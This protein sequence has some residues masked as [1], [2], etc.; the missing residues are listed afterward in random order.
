MWKYIG[1]VLIL[2]FLIGEAKTQDLEKDLL[3]A[4]RNAFQ[5]STGS[6]RFNGLG[7]AMSAI[8]ADLSMI[9]HNPAGIAAFWKSEVAGTLGISVM[10]NNSVLKDGGKGKVSSSDFQFNV[11][12]GGIVFTSYTP[13][14]NWMSK[15]FGITYNRQS[16]FGNEI[17][18][19]GNSLGSITE[20]WA[21][22]AD[23]FHP[24]DLK[25][26]ANLEAWPAWLAGAIYEVGDGDSYLY[27]YDYFSYEDKELFRSQL[28]NNNGSIDELGISFGGN[29]RNTFLIGG[30]VGIDFMNFESVKT[31]K[32]SDTQ[33]EVPEFE[34]LLFREFFSTTGIGIN[35][36]IGT[37]LKFTPEFS[38]SFS[39][40][41][42]T[43]MK[44][45]DDFS[46]EIQFDWSSNK[47]EPAIGSSDDFHFEYNFYN[48]WKI[49]SGIG[50]KFSNKG[51]IDAEV[52]YVGYKSLRYN[53]IDSDI[54]T[55]SYQNDLNREITNQFNNALNIRLGGE[56][57]IS[58]FRARAGLFHYGS[59]FSKYKNTNGF[60]LGFGYRGDTW[61]IDV[62]YMNRGNS[63]HYQPYE[64]LRAVVP[65]VNIKT[66]DSNIGLTIGFKM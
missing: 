8:G 29:F 9:S 12:Q 13:N 4:Y 27:D 55:Q 5:V 37:I 52:D 33:G 23:N 17:F 65:K 42:P 22:L 66:R 30:S 60:S 31:Y 19:E 53:F 48:P 43:I 2:I 56:L 58:S 64:F 45:E 10:T 21:E 7:G 41:S 36:K 49:S 63:M 54:S 46:T 57:T 51:F 59:P 16:S 32:E 20:R 47:E 14:K 40:A 61:F 39:M 15:S 44:L 25:Y 34:E 3:N 6:A 18:Y 62:S 28:I 38:W 11:P 50:Y 35:V 1:S 24:D 26:D